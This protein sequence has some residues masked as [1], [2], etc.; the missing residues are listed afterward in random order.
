MAPP[1]GSDRTGR[2]EARILPRADRAN[3]GGAGA[4]PGVAPPERRP[5][6]SGRRRVRPTPRARTA[7]GSSGCQNASPVDP[8]TAET[9]PPSLDRGTRV[10]CLPGSDLSPINLPNPLRATAGYLGSVM[11]KACVPPSPLPSP[12]SLASPPRR[13]RIRPVRGCGGGLSPRRGWAADG[14]AHHVDLQGV[15][16]AYAPRLARAR[17]R[18]RRAPT[19]SRAGRESCKPRRRS[20]V[21]ALAETRMDRRR[22]RRRP[23]PGGATAPRW[24][25]ESRC[26]PARERP[27]YSPSRC[28]LASLGPARSRWSRWVPE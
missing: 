12:S 9:S 3:R 15:L 11:P 5:S 28:R 26:I 20:T 18:R 8:A 10:P 24:W 2:P 17:R 19:S 14:A 21:T 13:P 6:S 4:P 7:R 27:S 1:P 16:L 22:T 25:P 23:W